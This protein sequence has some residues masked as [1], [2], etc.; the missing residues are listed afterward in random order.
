VLVV[1]N[2][3]S[4]RKSDVP[5]HPTRTA[6][7]YDCL[8]RDFI[9]A[10]V[11]AGGAGRV[12]VS[13]IE[14]SDQATV[15]IS[16][17]TL[18]DGALQVELSR[19]K[20]HRA[21]SHVNYL[22]ALDAALR[23]LLEDAADRH[24][25]LLLF[26]SDGEPSDHLQRECAHGVRVWSEASEPVMQLRNGKKNLN[27]CFASR[28]SKCRADLK[29]QVQLECLQKMREIG[30]VLG[31]DRVVVGTIAFGD[32]SQDYTVLK[33]MG[34]A[35]PRGSFRKLAL[36]A[37]GLRTAFSTLS[38]SLTTLTTEVGLGDRTVRRKEVVK[39]QGEEVEGNM[40]FELNGWQIYH[41]ELTSRTPDGRACA[42]AVP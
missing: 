15:V 42:A 34:E 8:V 6:A 7:V 18:D 29:A 3:G 12:V 14:M 41:E 25:L 22:P 16:K 11:A 5:G 26:L 20:S 10:Q 33:H 28:P 37:N 27:V 39:E 38:S 4:M 23:V 21:R 13:L 9:Q 17:A 36:N 31:W 24:T 2:S 1:D 30:D 40:V 19:R 32:V 35:L